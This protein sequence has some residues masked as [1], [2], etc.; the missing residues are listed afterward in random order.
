MDRTQRLELEI[1]D[2]WGP[3]FDKHVEKLKKIVDTIGGVVS[4]ASVATMAVGWTTKAFE[5]LG[6]LGLSRIAKLSGKVGDLAVN[7][8]M[9]SEIVKSFAG[10]VLKGFIAGVGVGVAQV[11]LLV[12]GLLSVASV[13]HK[14]FSVYAK[15]EFAATKMA[16][17]IVNSPI[18]QRFAAF[19]QQLVGFQ[20]NMEQLKNR[21][22]TIFGSF[23]KGNSAFKDFARYAA[24]TPFLIEQIVQS[25]TTLGAFDIA[26]GSPK[27]MKKY[28]TSIGDA[29]AA[30]GNS[31]DELAYAFANATAG[32]LRG[33]KR[34]G[35][36][37]ADIARKMGHEV[38]AMTETG[39]AD[40]AK[41]V[42]GIMDARFGGSMKR[43]MGLTL[44]GVMS[45]TQDFTDQIRRKM[46]EGLGSV[47]LEAMRTNLKFLNQISDSGRL[48]KVAENLGY[49]YT[50]VG[51]AI[52]DVIVPGIQKI[53]GYIEQISSDDAWVRMWDAVANIMRLVAEFYL[54]EIT[55]KLKA[56]P[57]IVQGITPL[58]EAIPGIM[59]KIKSVIDTVTEALKG[60]GQKVWDFLSNVDYGSLFKKFADFDELILKIAAGWKLITGAL[61][62]FVGSAIAMILAPIPVI[63]PA[64][65]AIVGFLSQVW[66]WG[67]FGQ[68]LGLAG[69]ANMF[70]EMSK[71]LKSFA[72]W[73]DTLIDRIY[74]YYNYV[75]IVLGVMTGS[76][77]VKD[78]GKAF[79]GVTG[80]R[81]HAFENAADS[82]MATIDKLGKKVKSSGGIKKWYED[83]QKMLRGE[84]SEMPGRRVDEAARKR[85]QDAER[86]YKLAVDRGRLAQGQYSVVKATDSLRKSRIASERDLSKYYAYEYSVSLA[87]ERATRSEA[88]AFER[89]ARLK[90]SGPTIEDQEQ[91]YKYAASINQMEADRL[92]IVE[93]WR[94]GLDEVYSLQSSIYEERASRYS[95]DAKYMGAQ[96]TALNAQYEIESRRL[97]LYQRILSNE[98]LSLQQRLKYSG[99]LESQHTKLKKIRDEIKGTV[100]DDWLVEVLGSYR[101][102]EGVAPG[103]GSLGYLRTGGTT[104]PRYSTMT[105][106]IEDRR[107]TENL[108]NEKVLPALDRKIYSDAVLEPRSVGGM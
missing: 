99:L 79:A 9:A 32:Q 11:G 108:I 28:I 53:F 87:M 70:H 43:L 97:K 36:T 58:L 52:A 102:I 26:E 61:K 107:D 85:F 65:A 12:K 67:D 57:K 45:N 76:I 75:K 17:V 94:D 100:Q 66:A 47:V 40:I 29:A 4:A 42:S 90:E 25:A 35:I 101:G 2:K 71:G 89:Y 86:A 3:A 13:A 78:F 77:G 39:R 91:M 93:G 98:R 81:F 54:E 23:E 34:I 104:T 49:A 51:K 19:G 31:I 83:F 95:E 27:M 60:V 105:F 33:L 37:S 55:D 1:E 64:L 38:D 8:M 48:D 20:V 41:A 84:F 10:G 21:L 16:S 82:A 74:R 50:T 68:A 30:T 44:T 14:V 56:V 18:V 63:G 62:A 88:A 5:R 22:T 15:I 80:K 103:K 46:G 24:H 92:Q 106:I 7:F 73:V 96:I 6:L 59:L 69:A 72:K